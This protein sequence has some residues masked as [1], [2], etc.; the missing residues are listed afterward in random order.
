MIYLNFFFL[1]ISNRN[2]FTGQGIWPAL[3]LLRVE[4]PA[5]VPCPAPFWPP[6]IDVMEARGDRPTKVQSTLHYG[7]YPNNG[8]VT[9]I[10]DGP[11]YTAGF[12][13]YKVLWDP[14]QVVFYVDGADV[15]K[16]T[17][18]AQIPQNTPM[19]LVMNTAVGGLYSGNPDN[20]TKFPQEFLIEYV[21]VH[22]WQ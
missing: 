1:K 16:V 12:H 13:T 3:W 21:T 10:K 20:T 11:D 4:C 15:F 17:D 8:Y 18:K 2:S 6:E 19:Y 22:R 14:N 5:A 7:V 9:E